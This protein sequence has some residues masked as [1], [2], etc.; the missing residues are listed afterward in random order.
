MKKV[1]ELLERYLMPIGSKLAA[2]KALNAV[3]D[4][5]AYAMP[6]VIVGSLTMLIANG[7]SIDSFK[8]WLIDN[9][10]FD[11]LVK[12]T[13]GTFGLMGLVAVFGIAY[14]YA[15]ELK[16][17]GVSAGIIALSGY[18][19]ST[20]TI[21]AKAGE[22]F[23]L[24]YMGAAGL[25]ASILIAL[26]STVIFAWFM[27]KDIRIKMPD[28]VPPAVA[29][30]FAALIPGAV[31]VLLWGAIYAGL[32]ATPM[33]LIHGILQLVLG[34]P[35]SAFGGSL[36]GAIV[37]SI[38]TSLF[39]F[40]GVHGG[41]VTG[42]IMSPI[43]LGLMAENAKVYSQNADAT[44]PHIV[45][46]PFMDLFVYLGG[47]GATIGLVAA[48]ILTAKS[49]E[50]KTL[51]KLITPPGL[52]NINEPTMFGTPVVLNVYL[53]I[54]FIFVPVIN[55]II[56]YVTMATGIV[57]A[58]VGVVIPWTMPPIISGFLATGS[59]I[60]GAV[61]QIVLFVLDTLLYIPFFKLVDRQRQVLEGQQV[62]DETPE[63]VAFQEKVTEA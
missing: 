20:P 51:A 38:V 55:A 42:A 19:I 60:S 3:R 17:D 5:I 29:N 52:F 18:V 32:A 48:M 31:I 30:S 27:K 15:Q 28:G 14:R 63:E 35:L 26:V 36:A 12:I 43:W 9:G 8:T 23:P 61:L 47:G 10:T 57:H 45:T 16:V 24:T 62:A 54:P 34:G 7:F 44:M 6:L 13:N 2:N 46:Q 59:H 39:W 33:A 25:F 53:L 50:F 21:M 11:W 1:T 40:I 56:A 4:G 58:T 41:N 37:V 22:G 49:K